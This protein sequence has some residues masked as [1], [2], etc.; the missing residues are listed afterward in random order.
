MIKKK[1]NKSNK[2]N[3]LGILS[4]VFGAIGIFFFGLLFGTAGLICGIIGRGKDENKTLSLIGIILSAVAMLLSMLTIFGIF[5]LL[6][7][8][9]L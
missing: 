5:A 2:S 6:G 4:V 8:A 3:V 1:T 7:G 9:T